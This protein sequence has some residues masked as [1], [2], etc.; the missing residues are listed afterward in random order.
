VYNEPYLRVP[1]SHTIAETE[2]GLTV[3]YEW[4][5]RGGRF[6]IRAEAVGRPDELE[7]GSEAEFIT[8][9]YWGY[10]RQKDGGT[11]EYRVDHPR[12]EVWTPTTAGAHGP[13]EELY[14]RDFSRVLAAEPRSA[15]LALGSAVEVYGGQRLP[16]R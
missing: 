8:E 7:A 6:G 4:E 3:G 16:E 11:L 10:T 12:W 5:H 13:F 2:R 1:M 15:F 14:G 9:H